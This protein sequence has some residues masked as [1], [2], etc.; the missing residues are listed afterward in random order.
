MRRVIR[1]RGCACGALAALVA[2][3]AVGPAA[4]ATIVADHFGMNDP[5]GEGFLLG[6]APPPLG[7]GVT[8]GPV[9]DG[10]TPAWAFD[11]A[12]TGQ[13]SVLWYDRPIPGAAIAVGNGSGWTLTSTL[14]VFETD[15]AFGTIFAG[16]LDGS[17]GWQMNFSRTDTGE[18]L[19]QLPTSFF[20]GSTDVL[21]PADDL[22]H[23]YDLIFDPIAGSADF[24]VD[25]VERL[26]DYTGFSDYLPIGGDEVARFGAGSSSGTGMGH[27][28]A[29]RLT[30]V[31]E[32]A[33]ALLLGFG[34][35][36]LALGRARG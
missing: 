25:G 7:G 5:L 16:Y 6:G 4:A 26:S 19:V 11:D 14:R 22:Y 35:A 15:G 20:G 33:S 32:P 12:S 18:T 24:F 8:D 10:G 2:G 27:F 3:L 9:D 23:T 34:L 28:N 1:A 31:P 17:T 13:A 29:M 36:G 21:V 30:I